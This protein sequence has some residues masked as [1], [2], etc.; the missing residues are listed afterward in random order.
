MN[1]VMDHLSDLGDHDGFFITLIFECAV[2]EEVV[3]VAFEQWSQL[4]TQE[5]L[6]RGYVAG[7]VKMMFTKSLTTVSTV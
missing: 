4:V 2:A 6:R 5:T 1:I 3:Y 7:R